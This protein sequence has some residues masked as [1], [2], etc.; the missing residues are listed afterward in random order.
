M[1]V[2]G[3]LSPMPGWLSVRG[4][5]NN[6]TT[7][8]RPHCFV[9][10]IFYIVEHPRNHTM[11]PKPKTRI[12][13]ADDHA[14]LRSGLAELL[15]KM[16]YEVPFECSNGDEL[17]KRLAAGDVPDLVLLDINM[18]VM[19]G[20]D[21]ADW[22]REHFPLLPVLALSMYD[23]DAA[24]I[25]MLR[26]GAKG[27]VLKEAEAGQLRTAIEDVMTK[28][29][30]YSDLVSGTVVHSLREQVDLAS[31]L[32]EREIRFLQLAATEMTYKQIAAEMYVS[33]R[34]VDGYRDV[35]FEKLGVTSR[36][37]LVMWAIKNRVTLIK[38]L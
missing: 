34:T 33:P 27:Y 28:G 5:F 1:P 26:C 32:S 22:I 6:D 37:G 20:F 29:F 16:E 25:K 35:L 12:A 36:V 24:I 14:V 30:H 19:N 31:R 4:S 15:K 18:P 21:T 10:E 7:I 17:I 11:A 2:N 8:A 38:N 9:S 23:D 3:C 13:L